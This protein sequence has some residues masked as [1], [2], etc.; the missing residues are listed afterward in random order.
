MSKEY[1][2]CPCEICK[3]CRSYPNAMYDS[4]DVECLK[5]M[6]E[7]G[8]YREKFK[9]NTLNHPVFFRLHNSCHCVKCYPSKR[10]M[11]MFKIRAW[12][13][14]RKDIKYHRNED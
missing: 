4:G 2:P 12:F 6:V 14:K 5:Y 1:I 7:M 13:R 9:E 8:H 3:M 10:K 11:R